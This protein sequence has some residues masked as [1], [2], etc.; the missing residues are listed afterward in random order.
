M[1]IKNRIRSG[2]RAGKSDTP[3]QATLAECLDGAQQ[4]AK[5]QLLRITHAEL[6][7]KISK[8]IASAIEPLKS[9]KDFL[10]YKR[11]LSNCRLEIN[12]IKA[13][14]AHCQDREAELARAVSQ[15]AEALKL[16]TEEALR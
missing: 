12:Q 3:R 15:F 16:E 9:Y 10:D 4:L 14:L 2:A 5:P 8:E 13:H 1:S 6:H 7:E 11:Q